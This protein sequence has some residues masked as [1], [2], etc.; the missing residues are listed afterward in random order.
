MGEGITGGPTAGLLQIFD[1]HRLSPTYRRLAQYILAH[2]REAVLLSSTELARQVG[3]SQPSVTRFANA[4]GFDGYPA[5][6][7]RLQ[8]L[9]ATGADSEPT[10]LDN[11]YQE[12]ISTEIQ[13]LR[14]L[15]AALAD[16]DTIANVGQQLAGANPLIV[17]GLRAST[18]VACYFSYFARKVHPQVRVILDGGTRALD[19]LVEAR[20]RSAL[21]LC[22]LLPR[23]PAE[24]LD[25]LRFAASVGIRRLLVSD[26]LTPFRAEADQVLTVQLGSHTVFDSHGAAFVLA[27]L[28]V[29]ALCD[30]SGSRSEHRL[31]ELERMFSAQQIFL[32]S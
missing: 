31:E 8:A 32:T 29:E 27:N 17:M 1:G 22:F 10:Q 24:T 4:V 18:P 16:P 21:L 23:Y 2:P 20:S 9:V 3:A 11:K 28:L 14:L 13:N 7:R 30:A 19:A 5:L 26:S 15:A 12:A 25:A 6:R